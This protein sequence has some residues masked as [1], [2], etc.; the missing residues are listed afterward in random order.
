MDG[1]GC[2]GS[3]PRAPA[4]GNKLLGIAQVGFGG[5]VA[6]CADRVAACAGDG[7]WPPIFVDPIVSCRIGLC[8]EALGHEFGQEPLGV[9]VGLVSAI[10]FVEQQDKFVVCLTNACRVAGRCL[11]AHPR[12]VQLVTETG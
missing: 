2:A 1:W 12:L 10:E 4:E 11:D 9:L 6:A 3:I 8:G 7:I 5:E